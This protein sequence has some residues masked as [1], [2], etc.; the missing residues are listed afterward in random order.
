MKVITE[1]NRA[2]EFEFW[3]GAIDTVEELTFEELETV[4]S[5]LEEYFDG[6]A[7][8]TEINDLFWHERNLIAEWLGY[9]DFDELMHRND[10]ED[11][12]DE[13]NEEDEEE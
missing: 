2:C 7:T 11:E 9:N 13:E 5:C 1:I 6:E 4:W 3:S 8:D 10:E 12:E